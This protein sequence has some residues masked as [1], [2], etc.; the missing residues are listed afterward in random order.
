M[1][2]AIASRLGYN[3]KWKLSWVMSLNSYNL[4]IQKNLLMLNMV[5]PLNNDICHKFGKMQINL[6]MAP[7]MPSWKPLKIFGILTPKQRA[8]VIIRK[9]RRVTLAKKSADIEHASQSKALRFGM[10]AVSAWFMLK[11]EGAK[12]MA[13]NFSM[14]IFPY[15]TRAPKNLELPRIHRKVYYIFV[16][17]GGGGS[18][19]K[20]P[21][22]TFT[23][24]SQPKTVPKITSGTSSTS[25]STKFTSSTCDKTVTPSSTDNN[26]SFI[27]LNSDIYKK[28]NQNFHNTTS[29]EATTVTRPRSK[30][31][32]I[33]TDHHSC[34][35]PDNGPPVIF[36]D[37]IL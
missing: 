6:I 33:E 4:Y 26:G 31:L 23:K 17:H 16:R 21:A 34:Y 7:I 30:S 3:K 25:E 22:L 19:K 37:L 28:A 29:S 9:F 13:Y 8:A 20:P 2:S 12:P 35:Q 36:S 27:P 5:N 14:S 11:D 10:S 15:L 18:G 24:P 32:P 1:N